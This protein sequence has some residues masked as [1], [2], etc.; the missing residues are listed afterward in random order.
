MYMMLFMGAIS[1]NSINYITA[2]D[3]RGLD[4]LIRQAFMYS[5][6]YPIYIPSIAQHVVLMGIVLLLCKFSTVASFV[7][8]MT[9]YAIQARVTYIMSR[10]QQSQPLDNHSIALM[11]KH[12]SADNLTVQV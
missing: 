8:V 11:E 7:M 2:V 4:H 10:K 12:A 3:R 9:M 1:G 5:H 6:Y